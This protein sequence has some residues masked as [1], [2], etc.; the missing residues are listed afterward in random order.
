MASVKMILTKEILEQEIDL[1]VKK[2]CDITKEISDQDNKDY[3]FSKLHA[4]YELKDNIDKKC[5]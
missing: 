2:Y 3:Y 4:L 5:L 1:L